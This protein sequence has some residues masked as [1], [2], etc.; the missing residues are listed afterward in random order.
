[1][2]FREGVRAMG[3]RHSVV[4]H[5]WNTRTANCR[6]SAGRGVPDGDAHVLP[7]GL[8]REAKTALLTVVVTRPR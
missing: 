7:A 6:V 3:V 1:M 2:S 8:L 5:R 4:S